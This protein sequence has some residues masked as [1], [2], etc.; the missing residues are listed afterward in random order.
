MTETDFW[1]TLFFW[2]FVVPTLLTLAFVFTVAV[3]GSIVGIFLGLI[4]KVVHRG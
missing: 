3:V 2:L 4:K 1:A